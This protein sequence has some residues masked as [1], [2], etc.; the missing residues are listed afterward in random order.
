LR[1]EEAW[2]LAINRKAR[3]AIN[4]AS[5]LKLVMNLNPKLVEDWHLLCG[6]HLRFKGCPFRANFGFRSLCLAPRVQGCYLYFLQK[7]GLEILPRIRAWER[8]ARL[9]NRYED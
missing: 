2:K 3:K 4:K 5:K 8:R 1:E 6:S 9:R 7:R